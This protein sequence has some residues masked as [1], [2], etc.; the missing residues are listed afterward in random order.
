MR[1]HLCTLRAWLRRLVEP[2]R[3]LVVGPAWSPLGR[4]LMALHMAEATRGRRW[5]WR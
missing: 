1:G 3:V 2:E 5:I 4:R